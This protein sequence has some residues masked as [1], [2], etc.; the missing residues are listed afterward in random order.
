MAAP[1]GAIAADHG[2]KR[3]GKAGTRAWTR[4]TVQDLVPQAMAPLARRRA[5]FGRAEA[6]S[7]TIKAPA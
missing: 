2:E 4:Q 7:G 5:D 3:Q 6:A 1:N